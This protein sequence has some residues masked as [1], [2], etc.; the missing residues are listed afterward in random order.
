MKVAA[1]ITAL[2]A[3]AD[4]W[5]ARSRVL[6]MWVP[7]LTFPTQQLAP[8]PSV[9]RLMISVVV[10]VWWLAGLRLPTLF[11][12]SGAASLQWGPAMDRLYPVLVVAQLTLFTE[13][14]VRLIRRE[15]SGIL[16]VTRLVWLVAGWIL[17]YLVATSDHQWMVWH[18]GAA[19]RA[20]TTVVMQFAGR[21]IS[22]VEF[23]N[24]T[25]SIIFVLVAIAGIWHSLIALLRRFRRAPIAIQA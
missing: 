7:R 24:Y 10:S 11:F 23:V 20:N 13:Q 18:A 21:D 2:G 14:F 4:F 19:T 17:I 16:R 3:F 25:W 9:S 12:G 8:E 22:L 15:N 6:E 5:L 1:W